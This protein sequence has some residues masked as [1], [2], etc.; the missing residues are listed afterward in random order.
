MAQRG[1]EW[2]KQNSTETARKQ[3]R[4]RECAQAGSLAA[5]MSHRDWCGG[6]LVAI[7]LRLNLSSQPASYTVHLRCRALHSKEERTEII[8]RS[9]LPCPTVAPIPP[10]API[11]LTKHRVCRVWKPRVL[12]R[13]TPSLVRSSRVLHKVIVG[14]MAA[15]VLQPRR[16]CVLK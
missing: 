4:N 16:G 14:A 1:A 15:G 12:R 8:P 13:G 5:A 11:L 9:V 10:I 2:K 6:V 7:G 3:H